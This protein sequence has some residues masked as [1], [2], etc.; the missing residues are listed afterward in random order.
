MKLFIV[1]NPGKGN[2]LATVEQWRPWISARVDIA[3]IDT[4]GEADLSQ[5]PADMV[6][7]LGGDGTLLSAARRLCIHVPG[8]S[9]RRKH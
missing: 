3:G 5:V 1:A 4:S 8:T 2:V 7:A 9:P 6:L